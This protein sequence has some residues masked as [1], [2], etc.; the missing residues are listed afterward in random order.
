MFATGHLIFGYPSRSSLGIGYVSY[1]YPIR[2]HPKGMDK[3][4]HRAYDPYHKQ[5][6]P[7]LR[8]KPWSNICVL[9]LDKQPM[10]RH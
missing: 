1:G 4:H 10:M 8:R 7:V 3:G 6:V 9:K 2:R 5:I